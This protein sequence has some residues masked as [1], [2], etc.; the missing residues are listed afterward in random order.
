MGN[1]L[2]VNWYDPGLGVEGDSRVSGVT[3]YAL[4]PVH[5]QERAKKPVTAMMLYVQEVPHGRPASKNACQRQ[6]P[7]AILPGTQHA[8]MGPWSFTSAQ[9]HSPGSFD[10]LVCCLFGKTAFS[11]NNLHPPRLRP[12]THGAPSHLH[13]R[14]SLLTAPLPALPTSRVSV[15]LAGVS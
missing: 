11:L 5:V 15:L 13:S 7:A 6:G 2:R 14:N 3:D 4:P 1:L 8:P 9:S 12:S 10:R